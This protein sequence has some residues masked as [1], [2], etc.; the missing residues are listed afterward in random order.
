VYRNPEDLYEYAC[1]E[2]NYRMMEDSLLGTRAVEQQAGA[3]K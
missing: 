2:G 1:H 3:K